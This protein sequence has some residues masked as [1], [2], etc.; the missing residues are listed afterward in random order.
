VV[1]QVD[2]RLEA[3]LAEVLQHRVGRRPVEAPG[4]PLDPVPAQRVA[5]LRTPVAA[6]RSMSLRQLHVVLVTS[7]TS[8]P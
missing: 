7:A 8:T 1:D 4:V 3:A 5:Q 2:D 6:S